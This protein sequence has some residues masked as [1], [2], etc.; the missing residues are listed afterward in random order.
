MERLSERGQVQI[1]VA[2]CGLLRYLAVWRNSWLWRDA[3]RLAILRL[4]AEVGQ[5]GLAMKYKL[6]ASWMLLRGKTGGGSSSVRV[7][8]ICET[9][10]LPS[11]D[12]RTFPLSS[13]N[14]QLL[15]PWAMTW[16]QMYLE[17]QVLSVGRFR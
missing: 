14:L 9:S 3:R 11:N 16:Q 17:Q 13:Y 1:E 6:Q 12:Y 2:K 7:A 15:S 4:A 10:N 8:D 5:Q